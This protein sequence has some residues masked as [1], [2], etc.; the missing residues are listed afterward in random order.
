MTTLLIGPANTLTQDV[1]YAL[2]AR[3]VHLTSDAALEVS[4]TEGGGFAALSNATT[5]TFVSTGFVKCT[6]GSATVRVKA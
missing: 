4:A 1:V 5:G 2:P 6:T 3:L